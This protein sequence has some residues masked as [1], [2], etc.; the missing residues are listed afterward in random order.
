MKRFMAVA[1][2]LTLAA[3]LGLSLLVSYWLIWPYEVLTVV[4]PAT[5]TRDTYTAG[6]YAPYR[7]QYAKHMD[8]VGQLSRALVDGVRINYPTIRTR[9]PEGSG[10]VCVNDLRIP[11][12]VPA[13]RYHFEVTAEYQVNPLRT[14]TVTY[15]TEEF[16]VLPRPDLAEAKQ[17][18]NDNTQAIQ[19]L[20]RN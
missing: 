4:A 18:L 1:S 14:V 19:R 13:G 11:L 5:M 7:L 15:D 17:Q 10:T 12:Y 6:D 2:I 3:A 16:D 8:V 9:L 20:E